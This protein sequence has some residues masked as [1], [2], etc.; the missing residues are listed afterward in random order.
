M[1]EHHPDGLPISINLSAIDFNNTSFIDNTLAIITSYDIDP[2]L[3]EIELTETVF[4]ENLL[5]INEVISKFKSHHIKIAID[6]FGTGYSSF[7]YLQDLNIDSL[8]IDKSF[9]SN[10]YTKPK[11]LAIVKSIIYMGSNLG[12]SVIAEGIENTF[13][14]KQLVQSG[15]HMGQGYL[16]TKP[17]NEKQI[18]EYIEAKNKNSL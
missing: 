10:I 12:L 18:I 9:I 16:F 15:C 7:S 8:K 14:L 2:S 17:V 11:S 6:D 5:K 13:E 1:E 4:S 3:I